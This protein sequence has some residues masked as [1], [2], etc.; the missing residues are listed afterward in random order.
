MARFFAGLPGAALPWAE[1]A[2]GVVAMVLSSMVTLLAVWM[3]LHLADVKRHAMR[4]HCAV[5]VLLDR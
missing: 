3:A 5:M 4:L 1:G 2:V